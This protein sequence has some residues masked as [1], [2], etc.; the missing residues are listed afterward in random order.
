MYAT[1]IA[2]MGLLWAGMILGISFLESWAKFRAPGLSKP[3]GL[4]VGRVVFSLFH[5]VQS[6]W[7]LL[8][9]CLGFF[10][11]FSFF[12]WLTLGT[13]VFIFTLQ[14]VWILPQLNKRVQ[15]ILTGGNPAP[16]F[17]H[18]SYSIAELAKLILLLGLSAKLLM[19][20]Y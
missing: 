8:I 3:V 9:V 2:M 16:S 6:V 7:L 4:E 1:L 10:A 14:S 13:L 17:F 12:D 5:K 18:A 11:Q 20:G 15:I 19:L